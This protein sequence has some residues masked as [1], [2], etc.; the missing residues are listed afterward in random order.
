MAGRPG[1]A[2][3]KLSFGDSAARLARDLGAAA[4]SCTR[5]ISLAERNSAVKSQPRLKS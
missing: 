5:T 4:G 3:G 1:A 2:P